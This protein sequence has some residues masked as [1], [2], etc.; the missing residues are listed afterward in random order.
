MVPDMPAGDLGTY[1]PSV[2]AVSSST[3]GW[4]NPNPS[5]TY[6]HLKYRSGFGRFVDSIREG[7][8]AVG[9]RPKGARVR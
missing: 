6:D 9:W 7:S 5:K 2:G 1:A 4:A 3:S 8:G